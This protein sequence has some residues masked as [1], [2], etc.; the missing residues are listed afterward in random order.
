MIIGPALPVDAVL[1]A[2]TFLP[3]CSME[4]QAGVDAEIKLVTGL[5]TTQPKLVGVKVKQR[6][7][8]GKRR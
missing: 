8:I 5:Q 7:E 2:S 3:L 4:N 6:G 1:R